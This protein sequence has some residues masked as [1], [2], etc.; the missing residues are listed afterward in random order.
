MNFYE[1]ILAGD[2]LAS[3]LV[4]AVLVYLLL[5]V[6]YRNKLFD[7]PDYR[8]I[9]Q[10]P[11]P[12]LG[13]MSFLPTVLTVCLVSFALLYQAGALSPDFTR[14]RFVIRLACLFA[15]GFIVYLAGLVDD[16][17]GLGYRIKLVAQ[18]LSAVILVSSGLWFHSLYGLFGLWEIPAWAGKPLTVFFIVL[19]IN[20]MNLIDGIDGL[21]AGLALMALGMLSYIFLH[22]RSFIACMVSMS[23]FGTLTAFFLFNVFGKEGKHTKIFMGDTGSMTLGLILSYLIVT[24][25]YMNNGP[26]YEQ[27]RII[28]VPV[29]SALMIPML[30][31]VR[32]FFLRLARHRNPF[33]PDSNHIHHRLLRLG[34]DNRRTLAVLLAFAVVLTGVSVLM[35]K[36]ANVTVILAVEAALFFGFHALISALSR[37][38]AG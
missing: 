26:V 13:G 21:S 8:K 23:A 36:W 9:H 4:D 27:N 19:L 37:E 15:G 7:M 32:L 12:R 18:L 25:S 16:F 17:S 14:N 22:L 38:K 35:V 28:L 1:W 20:S 11:V 30:E 5:Y 33:E 2:F 3:F 31:V 34:L 29:L 6:S 24:L 10:I